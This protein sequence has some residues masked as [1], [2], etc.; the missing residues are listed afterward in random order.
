MTPLERLTS[1]YSKQCNGDWEHSYGFSIDT[2]DN[3]GV[4]LTV[5]LWETALQSAPFEEKREH[6]DSKD[7]WMICSRT[8]SKFEARGAASRLED[9]IEEFLRW[10]E[11]N[12]KAA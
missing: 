6:Y 4:S 2:L 3:P 7:R 5:D 1:W 10:A 9:M 8:A 11:R 12:E